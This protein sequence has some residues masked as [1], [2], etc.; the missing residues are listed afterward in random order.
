[1]LKTHEASGLNVIEE[2][3]NNYKIEIKIDEE[4]LRI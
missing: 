1:L 4:A 3:K 2:N